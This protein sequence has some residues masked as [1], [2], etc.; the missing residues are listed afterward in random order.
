MASTAI[1]IRTPYNI[2]GKELY[3]EYSIIPL[4]L[5]A[6][7][8]YLL[9][10][11]DF[12]AIVGAAGDAGVVRLFDLLALR[13]DPDAGGFQVFMRAPFVSA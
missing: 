10:S 11:D 9:D 4:P 8:L 7:T 3:Q 13:A 1:F 2:K 5:G 6:R 12:A